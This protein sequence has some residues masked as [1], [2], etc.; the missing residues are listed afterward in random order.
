MWI[1]PEHFGKILSNILSN[2][3]RYSHANSEINI[4]VSK[5]LVDDI[6]PL[7]KDSFWNTKEMI[8]GEQVIIRV[9]DTG[10]G[11][12]KAVL[13][14][15]FKRFHQVQN[16]TGKQHSG[17]GIGLS[18]VKSLIELHHG[19]IIISSK[20]NAGTEVIIAL[21]ISDAYLTKEEK[22]EENT[23]VLKDY[24][25]NYAVE[26]APLEVEETTAIY[27]EGKPTILLVDDNHEILMILREYFVKEYNII[28]AIDG[29]EALDKCNRS[30]PDMIISD[31][32][33]PRMN[34]I[35]LCATL[36]KNLQ[37]C[38]IPIILLTAKSQIEDQIE[39]IEMGAD[40]YIPK[41]FNPRLLKANVRN[42]LNKSHQM[43]N[44][45]TA[46]NVR[47]EIQDK[48]QREM[49][50][51][52]I[53]LVNDNLTNQQF[54]VDH[55]CL[56]LGMNRT[57]LY[58]F[59]K[60]TTGMSLGNYIRKIRLDKAAELLRTTDMSISEVGYAVGIESPSYFTRTFKE[61]FGS[62]PSEFIKH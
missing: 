2:S 20:P 56:E 25:S 6:I 8:P 7:Y 18:L 62:A 59:I 40:A 48:R 45:P 24:L 38:F 61:Q 52:L 46:N 47:Q 60:S 15:I 17:S 19:G 13:P 31:V 14:T 4:Q 32:M 54:S 44:L 5:G 39:G 23:F 9:S 12:E 57:K 16:N 36:K 41:P 34:G 35:E 42:L 27:R 53:E 30:L 21:P 28:M 49:F 33:M 37:T 55:L 51:K 10:I 3:I 22:T 26:Y 43:R 58:S 29:Q 11:M 1:D 50:D